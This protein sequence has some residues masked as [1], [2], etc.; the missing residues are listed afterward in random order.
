MKHLISILKQIQNV[1]VIDTKNFTTKYV[2]LDLSKANTDLLKFDCDNANE[3][4]T[5]IESYL[6]K[7]NAQVAYGGYNEQR[8]LYKR[9]EIFNSQI[10]TERNIHIGID[11]WIK[12]GTNVL[13]ALDG[14][15]HSIKNNLGLGNYGPTIIL[16]HTINDVVF[17]TLYGH[18]SEKSI[19]NLSI[20]TVF[21]KGESIAT[22]GTSSI[23]GNYAPHLHFQIINDLQQNSGDYPGVCSHNELDFYLNNCPNPNLLLKIE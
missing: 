16:E 1:K 9:S 15:V 20:G 12:A 14:K 22:L 7:K 3:F 11:L 13:A 23:N 18:L 19:A 6:K 17:Y 5:Y 4:E 10:Q 2:A 8:S 21:C